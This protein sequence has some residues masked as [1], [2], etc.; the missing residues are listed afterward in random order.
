M[1]DKPTNCVFGPQGD[2]TLYVTEVEFGSLEAT[3]AGT[4]GLALYR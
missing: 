1:G 4:E 2:T 3:D